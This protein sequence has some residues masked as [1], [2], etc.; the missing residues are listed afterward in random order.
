MARQPA[1]YEM[2]RSGAEP[3]APARCSGFPAQPPRVRRGALVP[4]REHRFLAASVHHRDCRLLQRS[5]FLDHHALIFRGSEPTPGDHGGAARNRLPRGDRQLCHH[6][7]ECAGA[8][9]T[10]LLHN[11]ALSS[12]RRG[13]RLFGIETEPSSESRPEA[14]LKSITCGRRDEQMA[15]AASLSRYSSLRLASL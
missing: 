13:A 15:I 9:T 7:R 3:S 14:R 6:S 1:T 12:S 11:V 4:W 10:K 5:G 2:L 8:A